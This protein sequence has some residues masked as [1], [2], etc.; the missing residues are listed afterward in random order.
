VSGETRPGLLLVGHGSRSDQ[1]TAEVRAI[2]ALVASAR[3]EVVVDVGFLEMSDPPAG[4]VLDR[5][6]A[7]G[8]DPVVVLPFVL[9]GA[10]HAKNDV[11]ALVLEGRQ[12]HPY[13]DLRFGAPLGIDRALV[14]MLGESV[15]ERGGAGRPL[16]VVARGT[17]DP[18]ANGDAHKL[19]RLVAEWTG[20]PFVHT[21]F[22]GVTGP[23]VPEALE[24]FSRLGYERMALAF[25]FLCSGLLVDRARRDVATFA[26][27]T[28]VDVVDAGY[29]GPDPRLVP[30]V[31][32]RFDE[33]IAGVASTN[34]DLCVYRAPWPGLDSRVAQPVGVGHSHLAVEH[35]H[36][37]R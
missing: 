1:S 25:W 5:L 29:L 21:A 28:G 19:A 15:L 17:S 4:P 6:A 37:H 30:V 14:A 22:S 24:V 33:A 9:L 36:A 35:R 26:A 31:L 12:R 32:A 20:A 10:G 3:P 27:R 11:P 2:A 16:L 34:C 13:A 8:C 23:R 7:L 18:D